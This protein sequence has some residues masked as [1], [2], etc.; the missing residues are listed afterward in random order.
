M[1]AKFLEQLQDVAS[2]HSIRSFK[3][4]LKIYE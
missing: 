2:Y 4:H 1:N 3:L